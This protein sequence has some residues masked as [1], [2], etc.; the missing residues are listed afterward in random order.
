MKQKIC[1]LC[2]FYLP[3]TDFHLRP[4]PLK[5]GER[6]HR[7]ICKRCMA[8]KSLANYYADHEKWKEHYREANN[9]PEQV[10]RR[11]KWSESPQGKAV[12]RAQWKKYRADDLVRRAAHVAVQEARRL[13]ALVPGPCEV[14]SKTPVAAHHDDYTKPLEVRWLCKQCHADHHIKE[15]ACAA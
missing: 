15:R 2:E 10:E 12:V 7:T 9:R 11:R 1:N 5:S 13:G 8:K 14:C 4:R 6:R 3:I